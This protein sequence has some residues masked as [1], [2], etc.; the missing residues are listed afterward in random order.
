MQIFAIFHCF[1]FIEISPKLGQNLTKLDK[2]AYYAPPPNT[3]GG[4]ASEASEVNQG[5]VEKS[6]ETCNHTNPP[7]GPPP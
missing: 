4:G 7:R 3:V 5:S 1:K 2:Y 6:S